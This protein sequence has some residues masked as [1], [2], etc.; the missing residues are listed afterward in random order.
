[1]HRSAHSILRRIGIGTLVGAGAIGAALAAGPMSPASAEPA[2]EFTIFDLGPGSNYNAAIAAGPDGNMWFTNNANNSVNV[3]TPDGSVTSF[4]VPTSP[5]LASGPVL[6]AIAAGPDGN[7]WFTGYFA[8]YVGKVTPAGVVTTYQVPIAG[9]RPLDITAGPDGNMWFTLGFGNGI[10]RITPAGQFTMFPLPEPGATGPASIST[11]GNCP[12]CPDEITAG[13]QDSL[14]F[15]IPAVNLVGKMTVDGALT[16]FPITTATPPS[17]LNPPYTLG[18]ITSGPDGNLWI[19]QTADSKVSRMTPAGQV[20]DFPLPAT[21]QYPAEIGRGPGSTLWVSASK[22][23]ALARLDVPRAVT[24]GTVSSTAYPLPSANSIP[25]GV[26]TGPDGSV[27]F[28]NLILPPSWTSMTAQ[29]GRI[30]TGVGPI[31]TARLTSAPSSAAATVQAG[32]ALTCAHANRSGWLPAK[33]RY[34]WL[35]DGTP[36]LGRVGRTFTPQAH[37]IGHQ[38]SCH[39]AVTYAPALNSLG[40]TSPEVQVG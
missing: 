30:G 10:G 1:M 6:T 4:P 37:Q 31:L 25:G 35:R 33:V 11:T 29:V 26:A 12:M 3:I 15:T 17:S 9:G 39:V 2:G 21:I 28:T 38:I 8:N 14:W 24:T 13:P 32:T 18:G 19:A 7:M 34:Q 20:T 22:G 40:A 36:M 23:N 27:W 16:T 5:S